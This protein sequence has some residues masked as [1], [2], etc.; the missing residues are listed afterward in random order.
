[1]RACLRVSSYL[2]LPVNF[3]RFIAVLRDVVTSL[4][5][6]EFEPKDLLVTSKGSEIACTS[7]VNFGTSFHE[8]DI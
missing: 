4:I 3:Y 8:S 2:R 7:F 1:M 6:L 5:H